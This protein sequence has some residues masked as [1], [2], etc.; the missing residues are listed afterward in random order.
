MQR[1]SVGLCPCLLE[2]LCQKVVRDSYGIG[3]DGQ[4]GIDRASR[5]EAGSIDN[6]EIVEIVCL[7]MRI[8]DAGG[9]IVT[10][11]ASAVLMP[12]ALDRDAFLEIGVERNGSRCVAGLLQNIDPAVF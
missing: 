6:I 7:A 5:D 4:R 12:Y 8:K 3:D 10:H 1:S 11:A 2:A 9:R